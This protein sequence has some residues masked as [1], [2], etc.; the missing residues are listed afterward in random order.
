MASMFYFA[1]CR[2][3]IFNSL[4]MQLIKYDVHSSY[5]SQNKIHTHDFLSHN[6]PER[7]DRRVKSICLLNVVIK[8]WILINTHKTK[9]ATSCRVTY[10]RV[11]FITCY[12][13]FIQVMTQHWQFEIY[14][15]KN[16]CFTDFRIATPP[17]TSVSK[18][19]GDSGIRR[20]NSTQSAL[21]ATRK[22]CLDTD[23]SH[24]VSRS[25]A[26]TS[27]RV[28]VQGNWLNVPHGAVL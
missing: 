15:P 28:N 12:C 20:M 5:N 22:L 11:P 21:L 17:H 8:Q 23:L 3:I 9:Q 7:L 10:N 14:L 6:T 27:H 19:V 18:D 25:V 24:D 26:V 2:N 1:R 4:L 13:V 16:K